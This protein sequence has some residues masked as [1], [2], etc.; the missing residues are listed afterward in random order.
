MD[1]RNINVT[2]E[3]A[4]FAAIKEALEKGFA[5]K[6]VSLTFENWPHL[7]IELEGPGYKS[8]ITSPVAAAIVDLQ[9]ALNRSFALEVHGSNSAARLTDEEKAAIQFKATVEDGCTLIKVDLGKFAETLATAITDKMT[10]EMLVITVLGTVALACGVAAFK[11]FLNARTKDK[12]IDS[13]A[14]TTIAMSQEETARQKI[15]ADALTKA[16]MLKVVTENFD[17]AKNALLKAISDAET[18]S[19]NNVEIDRPLA[20]VAVTKTRGIAK[21]IQLNGTYFVT[22][23]NLR[24]EDEI[25]LGL[26][27]AQDGKTFTASFQDHSLDGDQIKLL[28]EAEWGRTPVFLNINGTELR[29]EITSAR[30]ISVQP[31]PAVKVMPKD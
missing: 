24:H 28:Q 9:T 16:P 10:P 1:Q 14:Q 21:D 2:S 27:R 11:A 23:T 4:A 3:A 13:K 6:P 30:V 29:G 5:N 31:Q 15:L 19:V 20:H 22:E 12:A 18:L 7:E 25:R 26:L 17:E 8:A